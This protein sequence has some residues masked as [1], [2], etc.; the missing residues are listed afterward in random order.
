MNVVGVDYWL[1]VFWLCPAEFSVIYCL[2]ACHKRFLLCAEQGRSCYYFLIWVQMSIKQLTKS[3][4]K[5]DSI[6]Q[7]F[8]IQK[9]PAS[10]TTI[11]TTLIVN[12]VL[13]HLLLIILIILIMIIIMLQEEAGSL[14]AELASCQHQLKLEKVSSET[15]QSR[16]V[17]ATTE[18]TNLSAKHDLQL[19]EVESLRKNTAVLQTD[20]DLY[21]QVS[22]QD[23][24]LS[25]ITWTKD[26]CLSP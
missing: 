15:L 2:A 19:I 12:L 6:R 3:V 14:K 17:S 7:Q 8:E 16:L 13:L 25:W 5:V 23:I 4:I 21:K 1:L 20:F 18:N 22:P 10:L 11:I 9:Q 24:A 26:S